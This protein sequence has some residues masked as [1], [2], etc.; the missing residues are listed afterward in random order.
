MNF[1][2]TYINTDYKNVS[3]FMGRGQKL[4]IHEIYATNGERLVPFLHPMN[5]IH[6]LPFLRLIRLLKKLQ[7]ELNQFR[8][9]AEYVP[10]SILL[11]KYSLMSYLANISATKFI[12]E[13][14]LETLNNNYFRYVFWATCFAKVEESNALFYAGVLFPLIVNTYIANY[15]ETYEKMTQGFDDKIVI[16]KIVELTAQDESK[17]I[18]L[19]SEGDEIHARNAIIAAP[20]HNAHLFYKKTPK[21]YLA[22]SASV[23]Y[24][25]GQKKDE[26]KNK[27][28]LLLNPEINSIGLIWEQ[29]NGSDLI[30]SIDP[31]PDFSLFYNKYEILGNVTWKT[32]VVL[33]NKKWC[34]TN[35]DTNIFLAGDYN[36]C[37]L[38]D[39]YISGVCAANQV[40]Q[41]VNDAI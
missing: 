22:K 2:A 13:Y 8:K 11:P 38:E 30:F 27:K 40:I 23:I 36:V 35:L 17:C 34:P 26:Y 19:T 24:V 14:S 32:A 1:G 21:P 29:I 7:K 28:F 37:G 6:L 16:D 20:Y 12:K 4:K 3:K 18:A 33:S 5:L 31:N 9:E 39:S 41:K 15:S 25:R 10:Q